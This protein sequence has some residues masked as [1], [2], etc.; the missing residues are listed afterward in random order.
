MSSS[1]DRLPADIEA[2]RGAGFA[3]LVIDAPP[4]ATRGARQVI[5]LADIVVTPMQLGRPRSRPADPEDVFAS[6]AVV[7]VNGVAPRTRIT[8][9]AAIALSQRGAVAPTAIHQQAA[10]ASSMANGETVIE[11]APESPS[12]DE[13]RELWTYLDGR[14]RRLRMAARNQAADAGRPS[15]AGRRASGKLPL[16]GK[17]SG[18]P[19]GFAAAD[20]VPA[21]HDAAGPPASILVLALDPFNARLYHDL[22]EV[23]G[24]DVHVTES[25]EG[26]VTALDSCAPDLILI[27]LCAPDHP[28]ASLARDLARDPRFSATPIVAVTDALVPDSRRIPATANISCEGHIVKPISF[29]DFYEPID[30]LLARA[31][32]G[33]GSPDS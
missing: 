27:E 17:G 29:R 16:A 26:W 11:T 3:L 33:H 21:Q 25:V 15:G 1:P 9:D 23:R 20:H 6:P 7:V 5:E 31:P 19:L 12:A 24:Y 10:I 22:L 13:I 14:L 32:G 8:I 30:A 18:A 28:S 4:T 2:I